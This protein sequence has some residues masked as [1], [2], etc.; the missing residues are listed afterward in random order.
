MPVTT[1]SPAAPLN[2]PIDTPADLAS[3]ERLKRRR[4]ALLLFA[5]LIAIASLLGV[6]YLRNRED[7]AVRAI[8]GPVERSLKSFF[9]DRSPGARLALLQAKFRGENTDERRRPS[10]RAL[11]KT[12]P[13]QDQIP[14]VVPGDMPIDLFLPPETPGELPLP[15]ELAF[16]PPGAGG[17]GFPPFPGFPGNPGGY[18]PPEIGP[19]P[20]EP[21]PLEPPPLEPP[22]P[23]P[24]VPEPATWLTMLIGFGSIGL[25]IRRSRK[26]VLKQA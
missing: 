22:P 2:A 19:P 17:G 1:S 9:E 21:P 8:A 16:N 12:F 5:I 23:V 18:L 13:P 10:Q 24:P 15:G 11:G 4:R 14:F 25:V 7:S 20:L 3:D 6:D 26:R